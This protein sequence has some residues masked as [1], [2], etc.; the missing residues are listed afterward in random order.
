MPYYYVARMDGTNGGVD[1]C[2]LHPSFDAAEK[3]IFNKGL[4]YQKTGS[5]TYKSE[6][7]LHRIFAVKEL[8]ELQIVE[9]WSL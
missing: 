1:H 9:V 3:A 7:K 4:G 2:N 5:G 8:E 6:K